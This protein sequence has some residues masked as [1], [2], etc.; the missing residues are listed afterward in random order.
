MSEPMIPS[1]AETRR[2]ARHQFDI[3]RAVLYR[4]TMLRFARR[5]LGIVEDVGGIILIIF[6][7]VLL[8]TLSGLH[9]HRGMEMI[10]FITTGVLNFWTFRVCMMRTMD[11]HSCTNGYAGFP[12]VTPLDV[13]M[14]RSLLNMLIYMGIMLL[15]ILVMR[16]FDWSQ[17]PRNP[18]MIFVIMFFSGIFGMCVGILLGALFY[19]ARPLSLIRRVWVRVLM[20]TSGTFFV[21]PEIPYRVRHIAIYNPVLHLNDLMRSMYFSTYETQA[22]LV[23]VA[24]WFFLLLLG[25]LSVERAMRP[26]TQVRIV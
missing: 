21:I 19:F 10:P 4:E 7:F 23:Y 25:A 2:A 12:K 6:M 3:L 26:L 22:S 24:T 14:A 9:S 16:Y 13:T 15:A 20:F 18:V 11:F 17:A 5:T 1:A 8:R